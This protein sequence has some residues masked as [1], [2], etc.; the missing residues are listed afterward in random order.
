MLRVRLDGCGA[1]AVSKGGLESG[2]IGAGRIRSLCTCNGA[3]QRL[4]VDGRGH[5]MHDDQ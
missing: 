5:V 4:G 1:N 2:W 3:S